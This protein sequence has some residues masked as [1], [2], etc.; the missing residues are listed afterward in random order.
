MTD[1]SHGHDA[2][3]HHPVPLT[4]GPGPDKSGRTAKL[5]ATIG[6]GALFA[7]ALAYVGFN[8]PHR[9]GSLFPQCMFKA[10]T[11]LECPA[12][13]GLRMT[14][15]LLHGDVA[16]AVVDN[17]Y[18]LVLLPLLVGWFVVRRLQKRSLHGAAVAVVVVASAVVWTV[19]RNVPGFPLVPTIIGG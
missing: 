9:A 18:L 17:I 5:V 19:V 16:A 3:L 14:H 8:D 2:S 12:C 10:L 6:T 4:A 15:D 7:G 11:G 13:G 1:S